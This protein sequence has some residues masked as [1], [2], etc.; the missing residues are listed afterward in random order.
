[1]KRNIIKLIPESILV[2][3]YKKLPLP[4]SVKKKVIWYGNRRFLVSVQG[5][6]LNHK[7]EVLLLKHTYRKKPWGIPG[8]WLEYEHPSQGL[9]R[10]IYEETNFEITVTNVIK[11]EYASS[12]NAINIIFSGKYINGE[13]TPNSEISEYGFFDGNNLPDGLPDKQRNEILNFLSITK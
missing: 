6:I 5:I 12:Q 7:N 11:T 2:K 13:F 8:G 10:E 9:I 3:L 4:L 1:M